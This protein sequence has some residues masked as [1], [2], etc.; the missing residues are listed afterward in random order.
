MLSRVEH[1]KTFY[2]L[3]ASLLQIGS[4]Q[5]FCSSAFSFCSFSLVSYLMS[6]PSDRS[7]AVVYCSS[8]FFVRLITK[9]YIYNFDPL[10]L[11]LYSKTGVY[12]GIR[13]FSYFCSKTQIVGT[14]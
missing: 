5:Y 12:R 9:T 8:S 1:E 2:N 3:G 11:L 6:F 14:R 7:K 13:D 10:T 4:S